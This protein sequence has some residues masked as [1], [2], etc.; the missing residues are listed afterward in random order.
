MDR[1]ELL[2]LLGFCVKGVMKSGVTVQTIPPKGCDSEHWSPMAFLAQW[3]RTRTT[4]GAIFVSPWPDDQH[5]I[6]IGTGDGTLCFVTDGTSVWFNGD[7]QQGII[8][9]GRTIKVSIDGIKK[10]VGI[11]T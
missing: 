7:S 10:A 1:T 2:E 5:L 4:K 9:K 6:R 8:L 3:T 11:L